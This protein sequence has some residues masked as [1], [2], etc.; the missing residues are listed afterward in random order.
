MNHC[1]FMGYINTFD[2]KPLELEVKNN[3]PFLSFQLS[4]LGKKKNEK[5]THYINCVAFGK[6][7]EFLYQ[8]TEVGSRIFINS[9]LNHQRFVSKEGV[10]VQ[11]YVF[12]IHQFYKLET[13]KKNDRVANNN[14]YSGDEDFAYDNSSDSKAREQLF[15]MGGR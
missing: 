13:Q 6:T 8:S 15:K 14:G 11:R 4:I 12:A 2:N 10:K 3:T 5:Y 9:S 7:A 1:Q